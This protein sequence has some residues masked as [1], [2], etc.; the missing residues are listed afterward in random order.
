MAIQWLHIQK[1]SIEKAFQIVGSGLSIYLLVYFSVEALTINTKPDKPIL[2]Q[3]AFREFIGVLLAVLIIIA[4]S[5][6]LIA[7]YYRSKYHINDNKT[8][9]QPNK[10]EFLQLVRNKVIIGLENISHDFFIETGEL[11]QLEETKPT[12]MVE[13]LSPEFRWDLQ[14]EIKGKTILTLIEIAYQDPSRATPIKL[15]KTLDIPRSTISREIKKLVSLSYLESHIS[16][17]ALH[18]A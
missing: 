16:D 1:S 6:S 4:T 8:I 11:P 2:E 3:P 10:L 18:D 17:F 13:Y 7:S 15:S 9:F 12:T 5:I 14:T